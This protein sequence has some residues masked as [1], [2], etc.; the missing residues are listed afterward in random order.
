[1]F[2]RELVSPQDRGKAAGNFKPA[3]SER[4]PANQFRV[5]EEGSIGP[6]QERHHEH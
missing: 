5:P 6:R 3:A 2:V 4:V 1:M